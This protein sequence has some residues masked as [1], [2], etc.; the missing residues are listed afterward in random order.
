MEVVLLGT[1]SADGWPNAFCRCASCSAQ[2]SAGVLRSPTSALVDGVLLLDCGPETPRSA[3]RAGRRLDD[4]TAVLLTHGHPD[5]SAPMALLARHWAGRDA[6]SLDVVGPAAVL[7]QWRAWADPDA[8]VR[9]R[10]VEAGADL[11]VA[12]HRVEVL[13]AAHDAPAVLYLVTDAAGHRLLHGCDTGPLPDAAVAAAAQARLDVL[14]LEETF[15]D[16]PGHGTAHL[17]L[18]T[19]PRQL[20]RLRSAGALDDRTVVRAVHLGHHN[21]PEARLDARLAAWGAGAG[22][23]GE[24]IVTGDSVPD[25]R[26]R[27][28]SGRV[29]V[30]G[31]ARS[32]KSTFAERLLADRDDVLYL[33]TGPVPDGSDPAWAG[34]VEN[35]RRRRTPGWTT[36]E[37]ADAAAALREADRPV[38]LDCAGTWLAGTLGACGAWD[39]APGW[40]DRAGDAVD[41][42][43]AAWSAL[44]VPAVAVSNEVGSGVV[45]ATVSGGVFRDWLGR[46]NQRL[47]AASERVVLTVAGRAVE[48][49]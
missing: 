46:L 21:P 1:G 48:L 38:L 30:L 34:R 28:T 49:P 45:P 12:G 29:L 32:G 41:D 3:L 11:T 9:W 18:T 26:A 16:H 8:P 2:A 10:G 24:R 20:A 25:A 44:P 31:G 22:R 6:A 19:F 47:A 23:D 37:T 27:A 35:H 39:D 13:P 33:A 5:H 36:V 7:E 14:L 42:L 43:V 15:G 4:V 40:Q 17:D